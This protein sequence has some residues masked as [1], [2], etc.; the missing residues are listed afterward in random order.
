MRLN[1]RCIVGNSGEDAAAAAAA[2]HWSCPAR[3]LQRQ[4]QQTCPPTTAPSPSPSA[5]PGPGLPEETCPAATHNTPPWIYD[6][7]LVAAFHVKS[8]LE[9][10]AVRAVHGAGVSP[11][12]FGEDAYTGHLC[13]PLHPGLWPAA[14]HSALQPLL[15][16]VVSS[17]AINRLMLRCT[18]TWSIIR[19]RSSPVQLWQA[20]FGRVQREGKK[21]KKSHLPAEL[22]TC[23]NFVAV[24]ISSRVFSFPSRIRLQRGCEIPGIFCSGIYFNREMPKNRSGSGLMVLAE[25]E[26]PWGSE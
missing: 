20:H 19:L 9:F 4:G 13:A 15:P 12:T 3:P 23:Y 2:A 10:P 21:G 7:D 18:W 6:G 16:A 1:L 17:S 22:D 24:N 8:P 14:G 26:M 11:L 25:H 5:S